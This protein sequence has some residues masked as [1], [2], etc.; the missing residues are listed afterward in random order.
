ML[1][2]QMGNDEPAYDANNPSL[3]DGQPVEVPTDLTDA[4]SQEA[5]SF[6]RRNADR[7]FFLYLAYN[8]VHSPMQSREEEFERFASIDDIQHRIFAAMLSRL[9]QG[10]GTVLEALRDE[11]LDRRTLVFFISD[12]G[13]P[14]RE[15]TS[16]NSP[17]RGGKETLFEGGSESPSSPGGREPDRQGRWRSVPSPHWTSSRRS[18]P[19]PGC[20]CLEIAGTMEWT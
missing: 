10:V 4:F 12:N 1:S 11:G 3:R 2:T 9:D 16:S 6:I 7:P 14:T 17:L 19:L 20:R 13:G 15:L 5:A 8:A 18:R